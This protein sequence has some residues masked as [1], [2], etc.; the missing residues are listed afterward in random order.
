MTNDLTDDLRAAFG[1]RAA[2]IPES[3]PPGFVYGRPTSA[4]S[5]RLPYAVVGGAI[6]AGLLTVAFVG[7]RSS[8]PAPVATAPTTTSVSNATVLPAGT[9]QVTD[10]AFAGF[11]ATEEDPVRW[12]MVTR[13]DGW[14]LVSATQGDRHRIAV[15]GD[16]VEGTF[17]VDPG[18]LPADPPAVLEMTA[19]CRVGDRTLVAGAVAPTVQAARLMGIDVPMTPVVDRS[20]PDGWRFVVL[21]LPT[22]LLKAQVELQGP[23]GTWQLGPGFDLTTLGG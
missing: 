22:D 20:D 6:A 2:E 15:V 21:E 4:R 23:D 9:E 16:G 3:E 1:Q 13:G 7:S 14:Q 19:C 10:G 11:Q 17:W 8:D 12:S 18:P 5:R